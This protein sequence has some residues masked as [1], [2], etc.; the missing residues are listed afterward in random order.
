M[1]V[2]LLHVINSESSGNA[3]LFLLKKTTDDEWPL[4]EESLRIAKQ[5]A[6]RDLDKSL[7]EALDWPMNRWSYIQYLRRFKNWIPQESGDPVWHDQDNNSQEVHDRLC[8]FYYLVDQETS[9]GVLAQYLP[10]FSN[11]LVEYAKQWGSFLDTQESFNVDILQTFIRFAPKYRVQDSMVDGKPNAQWN[12][13]NDFFARELNPGLRYVD[14][15][16]DN[17]VVTMPADCTFRQ[18]F[19]IKNDSSIPEIIIKKTHKIAN[20]SELLEGSQYA[21]SFANGT[22][23]HYFLSPSSY[24][25]FHVPVSGIVKECRPVQGFTYFG[26]KLSK[27]QFDAPDDATDGY[28]FIQA[29]GIIAIDTSNSSEGNIGIVAVLPIGMS[30]VSSVNMFNLSGKSIKKGDEFGYFTFGGSDIMLLFQ[31]GKSPV[32]NE[33]TNYRHYGTSISKCLPS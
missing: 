9:K 15:P 18:K 26:V 6:E 13:F 27:G 14:S 22:F 25:R 32:I 16:S 8:H 33:C 31:E 23:V 7:F 21:D 11:Y 19:A 30:Q 3:I 4:I 28:E 12:S 1:T 10:W 2:Q 5:N 20:I 17:T 24:H 29:R